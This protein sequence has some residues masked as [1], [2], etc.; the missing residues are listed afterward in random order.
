MKDNSIKDSIGVIIDES[1]KEI[2]NE[3]HTA[4]DLYKTIFVQAKAIQE[5][6]ERLEKLEDLLKH[7]L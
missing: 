3:D 2:A 4:V 5:L 1:P 7:T 6:T